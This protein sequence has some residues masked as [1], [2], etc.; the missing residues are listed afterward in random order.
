MAKK[1]RPVVEETPQSR[2]AMRGRGASWSPANR[3]EKLHVDLNDY[4]VVDT[5]PAAEQ[6]PRCETQYFRDGTKSIITSNNSPDVGFETS[7][8]PYRGCE[9]G[10]IY[11]Y[12]RPT[13]EY[14]GFSAGLDFESK[15]MVKMNAPELLRTELESPR[16][17]PQTLVMSGVTDPYQ[18]VEKKLCISRGC[19]EVLAKYRNAV[20]I[21]TKNRLVTRDIDILSDLAAINAVAVNISVTSLDSNLQ[22]VLEPRTSTPQARLDAIQQLRRAGIPAG[23]MVAPI[24]PGLTDHEVPSI[25]DACAK[26]G[27]QFAA[28]TIVRLPWAVAPLFEHWLEEHFPDRKEKVLG[29]IRH[30]RG[31][32]LNNSK[33]HTRMTGEGVFAEQIASMFAVSCR[34]N[35]MSARPKLSC[36]SF[37]RSTTQL[38]LFN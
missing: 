10:C 6:R 27:A 23:V 7:L 29:R 28:Y 17:V 11:C 8:N 25:L 18:P 35:R 33:W 34:R 36:A 9:H 32:R 24:I 14:L 16:W 3:F 5:D 15:I 19:L 13:H 1:F 22:R 37:Q 2:T 12:A 30:L 21:I 38:R 31:N 20:A 4:D 26:A